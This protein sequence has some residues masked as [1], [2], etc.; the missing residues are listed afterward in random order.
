MSLKKPYE[1]TIA[2]EE[3]RG[4]E[5]EKFACKSSERPGEPTA[6]STSVSGCDRGKNTWLYSWENFVSHC[7]GL[8]S[9]KQGQCAETRQCTADSRVD[10]E[11]A[12]AM[13][14]GEL[15]NA[16][17]HGSRSYF[18]HLLTSYGTSGK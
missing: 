9:Q 14:K 7:K 8:S 5:K 1:V 17:M 2:S 4:R 10:T 11:R 6:I 18:H 16:R 13:V 3:Y 12:Y 15:S